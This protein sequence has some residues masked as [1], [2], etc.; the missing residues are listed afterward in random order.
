MPAVQFQ[1]AS[2]YIELNEPLMVDPLSS[3]FRHMSDGPSQGHGLAVDR[4]IG[5]WDG[6]PGLGV[7]ANAALSSTISPVLTPG[8]AVF[9]N[10][11][12]PSSKLRRAQRILRTGLLSRSHD[13]QC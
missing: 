4:C 8:A 6:F 7:G 1:A 13:P 2:S 9:V 11:Q 5:V 3:S 10:A 12:K